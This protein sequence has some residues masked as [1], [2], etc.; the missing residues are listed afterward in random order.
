M[1]KWLAN[2]KNLIIPAAWLTA[3]LMF[4][5]S[6]SEIRKSE[7]Y[8][9]L[10]F[11]FAGRLAA[12]G[13]IEDLYDR[14]AYAPLVAEVGSQ[15]A[16]IP[17]NRNYYWNRPPF[18]AF[19]CIPFP[20]F[21][22]HT[23]LV[24]S[25]VI[26]CVLLGTLVWKLPIWFPLPDSS[27]VGLYRV[28]LLMF[29]PFNVAL[30]NGHDTL[31]LTLI[32]GYSL[33][34]ISKRDE[35]FGG[36]VL[37]VGLFKPHLIWAVPLALLGARKR[38]ALYSFL[39]AAVVLATLSFSVV[40]TA[41]VLEWADVLQADST[42]FMPQR[43]GNVRA[44]VFQAGSTYAALGALCVIIF[45]AVILWRAAGTDKLAASILVSLL[46][47]PHTYG[48]DFSLLAVVAMLSPHSVIRALVLLPW[49]YYYSRPDLLPMILVTFALLAALAVKPLRQY[50]RR[51]S[52]WPF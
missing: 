40:G 8:D 42:D 48:Y 29:W 1:P 52:F 28:C 12:S 27:R 5:S 37:A 30:V 47:S 10:Q 9:F 6:L 22:Y 16:V 50:P 3:I 31:F 18:Y 49:P 25:V 17:P 23:A 32:V 51:K 41:G 33:Y 4:G 7:P 38:R 44:L 43:M 19:L 14:A 20:W 35:P 45:F 15:G 26:N 36:A 34:R 46:L 39:L 13:Q 24:I 2:H 21:R 11:Y